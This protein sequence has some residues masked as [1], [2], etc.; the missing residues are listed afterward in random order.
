MHQP[1]RPHRRQGSVGRRALPTAPQAT[2]L[3]TLADLQGELGVESDNA[4]YRGL[5]NLECTQNAEG[6]TFLSVSV[7]PGADDQRQDPLLYDA[8]EL[9]VDLAGLHV[10]EFHIAIDELIALVQAVGG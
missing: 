5:Y 3:G 8:P 10:Y 2:S 9:F 6:R 7:E 1:R 4:V